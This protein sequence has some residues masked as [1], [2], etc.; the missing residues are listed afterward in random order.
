MKKATLLILSGLTIL[1][2]ACGQKP[3]AESSAKQTPKPATS[4]NVPE[5]AYWPTEGWK[6]STPEE[7]GVDSAGLATAIDSFKENNLHSVVVVRNGYVIAEGYNKTTDVE[8]KQS[9]FSVT[10]SITSLLVGKA[11]EEH[12]I[13]GTDQ[14]LKDYFPELGDDKQKSQITL[15]NM[16]S[17]TSGLDW[18]N[19]NEKSTVEMTESPDWTKFVLNQKATS[20]PGEVFNY[21]NGNAHVMSAV[22]QK[23]TGQTLADYAKTKLFDPL[24]IKGTVWPNDPQG[25]TVGAWSLQTTTRDMAKLGMLVMHNGKWADK[26]IIPKDWIQDA[27]TKVTDQKY[28]DGSHGGYGYFWWMKP[29][30][31]SDNGWNQQV[32]FAAGSGGQRIAIIPDMNLVVAM[33]ANNNTDAFMPERFVVNIASSVSGKQPLPANES[34]TNALKQAIA[35][36]KNTTDKAE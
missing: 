1:A 12:K 20:K 25:Y 18:N 28:V 9:M 14:K 3:P 26:Q 15:E 35:A 33:T 17:M 6:T 27:T 2:T 30:T 31:V 29:L 16:L 10:K 11:I 21:S 34:A 36:F 8:K 19:E 5:P 24:G 13:K 23:A 7:Q 32:I 4:I 22:V